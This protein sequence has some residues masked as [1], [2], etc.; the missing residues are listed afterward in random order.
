MKHLLFL[1]LLAGQ[2][3]ADEPRAWICESRQ[4]SMIYGKKRCGKAAAVRA[5]KLSIL[6][7]Y[8]A[9]IGGRVGRKEAM[10]AIRSYE[11]R[12]RV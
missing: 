12:E 5:M 8:E 4:Y 1:I 3:Q 11:C 6:R 2:V 9:E 7:N 10:K